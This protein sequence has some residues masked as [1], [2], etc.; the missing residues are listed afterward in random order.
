MRGQV[1]DFV[2]E[3]NE[4]LTLK[5]GSR[6]SYTNDQIVNLFLVQSIFQFIMQSVKLCLIFNCG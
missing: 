3:G 4:S 5:L 6:V 1:G 2:G